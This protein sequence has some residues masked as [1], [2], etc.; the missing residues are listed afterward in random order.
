MKGNVKTIVSNISIVKV[1]NKLKIKYN[2]NIMEI[3]IKTIKLLRKW[4]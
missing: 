2:N 4:L 1:Q 3:S